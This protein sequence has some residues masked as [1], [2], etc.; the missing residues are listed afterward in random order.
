MLVVDESVAVETFANGF[1][2]QLAGAG[3][4]V[5]Q[6][7]SKLITAQPRQGISRPDAFFDHARGDLEDAVAHFMPA[8]VVGKP[9]LVKVQSRA[10]NAWLPL[11]APSA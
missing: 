9:E 11:P 6:Q 2:H 5:F 8:G 10:G 4:A 7:Y 1:G 3:G